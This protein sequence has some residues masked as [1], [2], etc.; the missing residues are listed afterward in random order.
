MNAQSAACVHR[1]GLPASPASGAGAP[2]AGAAGTDDWL[3]LL[4]SEVQSSSAAAVARKLGISRTAVSLCLLGRYPGGTQKMAA[5]VLSLLGERF[6]PLFNQRIS[7]GQCLSQC[8][9]SAPLHNPQKM[10]SWGCCQQCA[11]NA[12]K[13][14]F[15]ASGLSG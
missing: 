10:R 13:Q 15:N 5:R 14:G 6:C 7:S 11:R 8:S 9:Q 4:K 2:G 3:S 12:L 1:A